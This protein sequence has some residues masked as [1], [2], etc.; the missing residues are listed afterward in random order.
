[1]STW[2]DDLHAE[3]TPTLREWC[4]AHDLSDGYVHCLTEHAMAELL[5]IADNQEL[6]V[7]FL[8]KK[9]DNSVSKFLTVAERA[10]LLAMFAQ[11][12]IKLAD[13][14]WRLDGTRSELKRMH[15]RAR[16]LGIEVEDDER[17]EY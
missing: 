17:S 11:N 1:M 14:L 6:E 15:E 12:A 8:Q 9:L 5:R 10:H 16:E 13:D 7:K 2:I 3:Q 4:D